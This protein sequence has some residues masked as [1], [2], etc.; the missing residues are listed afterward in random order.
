MDYS[1][2]GSSVHGI[3]QARIL[4]WVS[5]S[6]SR[7]SSQ[8]RDRTWVSSI[9]GAFFTAWATRKAL[10]LLRVKLNV[11]MVVRSMEI[12]FIWDSFLV[13]GKIEGKRKGD[14]RGWDGW[15]ASPTQWAWIWA[16]SKGW[17]WTGKPGVLRSMGSQRVRHDWV[18]ELAERVS[19]MQSNLNFTLHL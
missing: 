10:C 5:I 1:P 6:F 18:T 14:G 13:L 16:S 7:K 4:E 3:L 2:P 9:A 19:L 11:Y 8:A 15:M 12:R 17:W